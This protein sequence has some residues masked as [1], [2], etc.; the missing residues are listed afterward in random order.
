MANRNV[1]AVYITV[2]YWNRHHQSHVAGEIYLRPMGS[3]DLGDMVERDACSY[4]F[5]PAVCVL[6]P[7]D[8]TYR[9]SWSYIYAGILS[10]IGPGL[11]LAH[12]TKSSDCE[13]HYSLAPT[14]LRDVFDDV[15]FIGVKNALVVPYIKDQSLTT[16]ELLKRVGHAL[17]LSRRE[18]VYNPFVTAKPDTNFCIYAPKAKI[19][20]HFVAIGPFD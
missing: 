16:E 12:K 9:L 19:G 20:D 10:W 7:C 5:T 18:I 2:K 17:N 4:D 13:T 8:E 1:Y 6:P 11:T 15:H 3:S 14:A